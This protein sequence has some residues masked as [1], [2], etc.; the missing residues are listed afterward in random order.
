MLNYFESVINWLI[1]LR[2]EDFPSI[3]NNAD[4]LLGKGGGDDPSI[5]RA[6]NNA[7]LICLTKGMHP[8]YKQA[9]QYL[10]RMSGSRRWEEVAGFYLNGV[11]LI[12]Q[13]I[14]DIC[15]RDYDF[16]NRLKALFNRISKVEES[17]D[18]EDAREM[19]WS[20]FFPE[21]N[22]IMSNREER[23]ED[24]RTKRTVN[25]T[26]LNRSPIK[27][28]AR[29]ILFTS[30][31]LLTIPP[32]SKPLDE[33]PLSRTLKEKLTEISVEEQVYWYDHPIQ[34]GVDQS[35]NEFLYGLKGL[36]EAFLF[37]RKR[38]NTSKGDELTC[39]LSVSVTHRGLQGIAKKYLEEVIFQS[40][41]LKDMDV[42]IFTESDTGRIMEEIISP[43][44][45]HYLKQQMPEESLQMFGVDGKYG[46]HYSFLKAVAAFWNILIDPQKKATFKIDLDQV[47]PQKELVEET[48]F[49]VFEHLKTPLWGAKGLDSAGRPLEF[50]MIAGAL[51]N[52]RDIGNS[53]FVPDVAF[54]S[55]EPSLDE[56]IFF[57][58]LPQALSTE[59]E[60]LT[61]YTGDSLDGVKKCIQ[62]IHV[63]GGTNGILINSLRRHRPFTPSFIG[64]AEDQAY[65]L[66]ALDNKGESLAYVHKDG[67]IM[68]HDKEGFAQDAIQ[69]ASIAKLIGDYVRIFYFSAY[70]G[71][72]QKEIDEL[73]DLLDP[74]TGCFISKIPAVVVYLRFAFKAASFFSA[75]N[76]DQGLEFLDSGAGRITEALKFISGKRSRLK[77]QYIEERL[78]WN[79]Y[80]DTLSA[81]ED[82]LDRKDDFAVKLKK[83]A[84]DL[85]HHCRIHAQ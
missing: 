64:R 25:V 6:L 79:L 76:M 43:A 9:E 39:L 72:L 2:D 34:I 42:Y 24:L 44:A 82:G 40:E 16:G 48:G 12:R 50:G 56:Y 61:R 29:Q 57:S 4:Q 83:K 68:R 7:F 81:I 69:S 21:A 53:L 63:T 13:E 18:F 52:E 11:D 41:G 23:V 67:L 30:N 26:G 51:V 45:A 19:V 78:G 58:L 47:F 27:D 65:I 32:L 60:M 15:H 31:V 71:I 28:P 35:K 80:Y 22:G 36:E 33:L 54:P 20:V 59:A 5:A 55:R 37:E 62:R 46:R 17:G 1:Q 38:G 75:G 84:E 73:K 3:L 85:I 77:R 49:S 10:F 8:G 74:F 66:S 14:E 70:A